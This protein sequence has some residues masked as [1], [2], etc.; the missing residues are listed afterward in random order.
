M[1]TDMFRGLLGT[2]LVL[3]LSTLAIAAPAC[4]EGPGH[5]FKLLADDPNDT[6]TSPDHQLRIEQYSR[7]LG[8]EGYVYQFWTFDS[9]HRHAFLLNRGENRDY[10][11]YP[12]GFRFT[13]DSKW[14]WGLQKMGRGSH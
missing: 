5:K 10:A 6:M 3:S 2:L 11:G 7:D 1:D 12:A 9:D 4:A 8:D 13:A 14:L